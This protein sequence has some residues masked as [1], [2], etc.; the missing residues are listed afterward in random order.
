MVIIIIIII[1]FISISIPPEEMAPLKAFSIKIER[2]CFMAFVGIAPVGVPAALPSI[3]LWYCCSI[4]S[5]DPFP[6][7]SLLQID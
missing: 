3:V 2:C 4:Y 1:T 7:W 5:S 6:V